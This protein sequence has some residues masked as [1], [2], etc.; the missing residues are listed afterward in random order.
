MATITI[1]S[2]NGHLRS[3]DEKLHAPTLQ[4]RD[5]LA[6]EVASVSDLQSKARPDLKKF[7]DK[8]KITDSETKATHCLD[9]GHTNS[10]VKNFDGDT[11][12]SKEFE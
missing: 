2:I 5:H 8:A 4:V 9:V 10:G 12:V 6:L 11:V 3:N 7:I 1:V